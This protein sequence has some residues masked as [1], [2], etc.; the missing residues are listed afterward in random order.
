ME[1]NRSRERQHMSKAKTN[2]CICGCGTKVAGTF[3]QGHDQ[4]VRGMIQRGE[5]NKALARARRRGLLKALRHGVVAAN[6]PVLAV[7]P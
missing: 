4:R 6:A 5:T 2:E 7:R 1:F 3:A